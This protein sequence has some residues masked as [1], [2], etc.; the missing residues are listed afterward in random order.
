MPDIGLF[1]PHRPRLP[2]R[3]APVLGL[4]MADPDNIVPFPFRRRPFPPASVAGTSASDADADGGRVAIVEH[5]GRLY[6]AERLMRELPPHSIREVGATAPRSPQAFW[7][8]VVRRWPAMADE[9]TA[10]VGDRGA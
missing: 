8:E 2:T 5:D 4:G 1:H 10:R 3:L 6:A 7:D 9:I